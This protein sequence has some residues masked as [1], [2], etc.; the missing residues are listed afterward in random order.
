[1]VSFRHKVDAVLLKSLY[2][3]CLLWSS[4]YSQDV[5]AHGD[6]DEQIK[7]TSKEIQSY[8]DSAY[9][10]VKLGKLYFEHE[11]YQKTIIKL[12]HATSLGYKGNFCDLLYAKTY[13]KLVDF[14]AA[15]T[16]VKKLEAKDSL[17]VHALKVKAQIL[18]AQT[19]FTKSAMVLEQI[20]KVSRNT[21]P[22]NYVEAATAWLAANTTNRKERALSILEQGIATIGPLFTFYDNIKSLHLQHKEYEQALL[23]QDKIIALSQRKEVAYYNAAE[24][25]IQLGDTS[26]SSNYLKLAQ[27]AIEQ[28][29][30]R[31]QNSKRI[32]V[33]QK[34][35]KQ[36]HSLLDER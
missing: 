19:E 10:Y 18:F 1:V 24:L 22:K 30:T 6:L 17:N 21:F 35:I 25:C 14:P 5:L 20:I 2:I 33:L 31:L 9:L 27:A 3:I 16:Y 36:K 4:A 11:E 8:P 13:Q 23:T 28:L 15:M 29:P 32:I 12:D 26:K 7:K 34:Q